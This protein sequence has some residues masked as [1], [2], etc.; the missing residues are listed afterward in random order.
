MTTNAEL[1][2]RADLLIEDHYQLMDRLIAI[3]KERGLDVATVAER[4]G[5]MPSTVHTIEADYGDPTLSLIR[6][7]ALA[8]GAT[9]H[10]T[11]TKEATA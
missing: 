7:Y 6:R 8:V 11:V 1:E 4:M 2:R 10:T 3:R 5:V 9:T